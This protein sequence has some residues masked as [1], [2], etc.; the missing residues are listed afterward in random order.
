MGMQILERNS[1]KDVARHVCDMVSTYVI[2][3]C[4]ELGLNII[5]FITTSL[6]MPVLYCSTSASSMVRN[7]FLCARHD[8]AG[9]VKELFLGC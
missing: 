4:L 6:L 8:I 1:D 3:T 2:R 9:M 5:K 7:I